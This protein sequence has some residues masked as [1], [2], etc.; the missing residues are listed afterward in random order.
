[1]LI[2]ND[3]YLPYIL[4]PKLL[5]QEW[6]DHPDFQSK[7]SRLLLYCITIPSNIAKMVVEDSYLSYFDDIIRILD[8]IHVQQKVW[9]TLL[10]SIKSLNKAETKNER[11]LILLRKCCFR[12]VQNSRT[13]NLNYQSL[14]IGLETAESMEDPQL[15]TAILLWSMMNE[16]EA[17]Q[18]KARKLVDT[19]ES[20]SKGRVNNY[21]PPDAILRCLKLCVQYTRLDLAEQIWNKV[22]SEHYDLTLPKE[23]LSEF[24]TMMITIYAQCGQLDNAE[25]ILQQMRDQGTLFRYVLIKYFLRVAAE[26]DL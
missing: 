14:R 19:I 25:K 6:K 18:S 8:D 20:S 7:I 24:Q 16:N 3:F 9:N 2:L 12:L 23:L 5:Q 13:E 21:V 4:S 10:L 22:K 11:Q 17:N 15:A 1:M 26:T